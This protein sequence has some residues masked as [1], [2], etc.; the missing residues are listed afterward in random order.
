MKRK[1]LLGL[2]LALGSVAA[3]AQWVPDR[4]DGTYVN[5]IIFADYADPDAIRVGDDYWMVASSFTSFPG[6]PVL[7]SRDMVNWEIV[8]YVYDRLPS[9]KYDRPQ[10]GEGSWAPAIRYHDGMY[11]VYFCTPWDGL[12]VARATDPRGPWDLTCMLEVT[13]WEDPCPFW[14]EDG[15]AY[16][17]H[18]IHRGGPAIIHRM[19]PD[20]LRL[21]DDGVTVYHDAKT[22][23]VLEGMKMYKRDGW[24]YILAPAGGVS[25][26][27]QTQLRSRDIYGPYEA[28]RIM[29]QG[30]TDINGPH[31]G[32]LLDTPDGN[33]WWFINFQSH[34]IHG[35]VAH[36]QPAHWTADGNLV[37]GVDPDGDGTGNPVHS[38]RT[39]AIPGAADIRI[40]QTSDTF[41]SP[42]R[43]LQWQWQAHERPEWSSLTARPGHMRLYAAQC[44]SEKGNLYYAGNL[45]LQKLPEPSYN[46]TTALDG[47]ALTANGDRAGLITMGDE[48]SY[49]ALVRISDGWEI[50]VVTGKNDRLAVTPR[51]KASAPVSNPDGVQLRATL[52][53]GDMM[54]YS[55]SLDGGTTFIPLGKEYK[56]MPG[57][58]VGAKTGIFASTPSVVPSQGYA[59]FDWFEIKTL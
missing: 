54:S 50:Q 51:V 29:E 19:S 31:Q 13:K 44:P 33:E 27:W 14:D 32:A 18:S 12:Y 5:P 48:Y 47:S 9:G 53:G 26:G 15:Q 24:Y 59:D 57:T 20:G 41:D 36:L 38:Y 37:I 10:H 56:V 16:L 4:G 39:P 7:H 43:G 35:R 42:V 34:G 49:I 2:A 11:Y 21:L 25:K 55:Y 1:L 3:S 58:W 17:V 46:A 23:P 22:N 45:L 52:P 40:P 6:I 28:R 30:D 8:S